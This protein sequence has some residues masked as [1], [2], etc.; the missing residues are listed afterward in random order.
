MRVPELPVIPQSPT[1][2]AALKVTGAMPAN[3]GVVCRLMQ[4]DQE[5]D[6]GVDMT[7]GQLEKVREGS[8][9]VFI[10]ANQDPSTLVMFCHGNAIP[11]LTDDD[12]Q[13]R[14]SYT[15]CP[16]WQAARD[17]EL[18]GEDGLTA[19]VIAEPTSMGVSS[20]EAVDPWAAAI[21]GLR[22]LTS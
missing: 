13:G 11:V 15:Y 22:E 7:A 2:P 6:A 20:D 17:R 14:A 8:G 10:S 1:C 18:A 21:D 12:G 3:A 19:P 16:V 4:E 9:G 5:S